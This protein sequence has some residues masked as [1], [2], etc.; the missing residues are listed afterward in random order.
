MIPSAP[1]NLLQDP[2]FSR[3]DLISCRNLL[4]YLEPEFQK[5]VLRLFHFAL[6]EGGHLFLGSAETIAGQEDLFHAVS[7]KWRIY[8]RIGPTRHEVVDFPLLESAGPGPDGETAAPANA[9]PDAGRLMG[10]ALL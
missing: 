5:R 4:I 9:A 1:K 8:R 3:L 7:K 2:P 10:E 6:R